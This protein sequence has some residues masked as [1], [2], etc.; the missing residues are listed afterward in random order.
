ME[1]RRTWLRTW[2]H[3]SIVLFCWGCATAQDVKSCPAAFQ[4]THQALDCLE[5]L[6]TQTDIPY[7]LPHLTLSSIAPG[8]GM[9]IG[10]VWEK[11]IHNVSSPFGV[12]NAG[13]DATQGNKSLTDLKA[14][15]VFSTNSSWYATGSLVWLPPLPYRH[16]NRPNG[17]VCHK[18]GL[19]CTESVF[20]IH[21]YVTNGTFQSINFFGLGPSSSNSSASFRQ[22]QVYGGAEARMPIWNWLAAE[23]QIE[24]LQPEITVHGG[25]SSGPL[26]EQTAPGFGAQPDFMHY[27]AGF[28]THFQVISEPYTDDPPTTPP[29]VPPP[30]LQKHKLILIFDNSAMEHWF[31]DQD[32]GHYSFR[33]L[34]LEGQETIQ[35]HFVIRRFV[36]P[37]SMT[38]RLK[39][40][41][42]FCNSRA[43]GLKVHDECSFGEFRIRPLLTLSTSDSGVVPFYLQPTLGGSDIQSRPTLRGFENYRFRAPDS[44]M[45]GID[46]EIPVYN[47][48]G[49]LVFYDV[50][51]V[52]NTISE[53]SFAH[54][55]QDGGMGVT[56]RIQNTAIAQIYLAY[57]AGHGSHFGYNF[58]KFF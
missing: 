28:R 16:E 58:T 29:G 41:K 11:R 48:L 20:G 4:N 40:L 3:C 9:P 12:S 51:Q 10:V 45:V 35:L 30:L 18:L 37:S 39:V 54:A 31:T 1:H 13:S 33:Q 38:T 53:L 52:G 14:A 36:A 21:L 46:Y 56:L 5:A 22:S 15:I 23:G 55:R 24:N 7:H 47:P 34:A 44:A 42:H 17:Q 2:F 19:L 27:G 26:T 57:G 43:S 6:F 8:N 32:T 50:G 25:I 49:A